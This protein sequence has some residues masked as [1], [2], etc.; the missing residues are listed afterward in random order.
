[1][2]SFWDDSGE[3][4]DISMTSADGIIVV[5]N[6][7]APGYV[8]RNDERVVPDSF[9]FLREEEN[10]SQ[11]AVQGEEGESF[12]TFS[13][14]SSSTAS[15]STASSSAALHHTGD[16]GSQKG[17]NPQADNTVMKDE[18]DAVMEEAN[19]DQQD[20]DDQIIFQIT[21]VKVDKD[22]DDGEA[23]VYVFGTNDEGKGVAVQVADA[24]FSVYLRIPKMWKAP[25]IMNNLKKELQ[26]RFRD[27]NIKCSYSAKQYAVGFRPME[28]ARAGGS[29]VVNK[30]FPFACISTNNLRTI[31]KLK[32]SFKTNRWGT[33][34]VR[35][36]T[37]YEEFLHRMNIHDTSI[38]TRRSDAD[39]LTLHHTRVPFNLAF[40]QT[41][42]SKTSAWVAVPNTPS[43]RPF[44]TCAYNLHAKTSDF[45]PLP[46]KTNVA[47]A[48]GVSFDIETF[49][50][51]THDSLEEFNRC[52]SLW[53]RGLTDPMVPPFEL[54]RRDDAETTQGFAHWLVNLITD[55][56]YTDGSVSEYVWTT[57]TLN[58]LN[59]CIW[60]QSEEEEGAVA[61]RS[62]HD[63]SKIVSGFTQE[64]ESLLPSQPWGSLNGMRAFSSAYKPDN[65]LINIGMSYA[66]AGQSG[67][68]ANEVLCLG[69]TEASEDPDTRY[70]WFASE[71][72]LLDAFQQ[73]VTGRAG[74]PASQ[75]CDVEW[76]TGYNIF[77][78]DVAY[79]GMR[80]ELINYFH[81]ACQSAQWQTRVIQSWEKRK[82]Q[83]EEFN[84]LVAV[85]DKLADHQKRD[86]SATAAEMR[87]VLQTDGFGDRKPS[88]PIITQMMALYE[89][90]EEVIEAGLY[91]GSMGRTTFFD[92]H[93]LTDRPASLKTVNLESAAFGQ[94]TLNRVDLIGRWWIDMFLN[95]KNNA[96]FKLR[97]YKLG[98]VSQHFLKDDKADL[99]YNTMFL[100]WQS[101]DAMKRRE[102]AHYC[103]QDCK[104][105]IYLMDKLATVYELIEMSRLC[106]TSMHE[107]VTR[108][109]QI[110]VFSQLIAEM[111]DRNM[112][113][114]NFQLDAP[115]GGYVGATVLP[116][117]P[118][119]HKE[120]TATLD[121]ASL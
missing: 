110:K 46:D 24:E 16:N 84:R 36:K 85:Y 115:S 102:V 51:V 68:V 73:R 28:V 99:D 5:E 86:K 90:A 79:L 8:A 58:R 9:S 64:F 113:L 34:G 70:T 101:G 76:L 50:P 120:F 45:V 98:A 13:F 100:H 44:S 59:E 48:L 2:A 103:V 65:Y 109:Q 25:T 23:I 47:P 33:R 87:Q 66:R 96:G 93:R 1:M 88:V 15:S 75:Q 12:S 95:I 19:E 32:R 119:W 78:F 62:A 82:R 20:Q 72:E 107:L 89:S 108:G 77:K 104:L 83:M 55:S 11:T 38:L 7:T 81:Y 117:I 111:E 26:R 63:L 53:A 37:W 27:E 31:S 4:P 54:K 52:F 10:P 105:V 118:G 67:V 61:R 40:T 14:S 21:E 35:D 43:S 3:A 106:R 6:T 74:Y 30:I 18:G 97:S 116:P 22:E 39:L 91:F 42:G 94:N 71:K 57:I 49:S 17:E 69:N 29:R 112:V 80:A 114:N 56:L 92:M 121:F 41:I 60:Y